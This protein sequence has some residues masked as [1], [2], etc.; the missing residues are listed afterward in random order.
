MSAGAGWLVIDAGNSAIK[1]AHSD[2]EG[3]RFLGTGVEVRLSLEPL[4]QRLATVWRVPRAR[5]AFGCCV[6][7]DETVASI[8]R[9]TREAAGIGVTWLHAQPHFAGRGPGYGLALINTYRDARELHADRWH[10]MIAACAKFPGESLVIATS[11][12]T[13]TVDCVHGEPAK[14]AVFVGGVIAPGQQP[15]V[16]AVARSTGRL[17][18]ANG[19]VVTNPDNTDDAIVTGV[20]YAQIGLIERKTRDFAAELARE[21]LPPPRLLLAGGRVRPLLGP[22][23]R[24]L[25]ADRYAY[26]VSIEDNL[27]LRG[28]ALRAHAEVAESG[29][30]VLLPLTTTRKVKE[31]IA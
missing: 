24:T 23:A 27:V 22:L 3:N 6:A 1:W 28:V 13:V 11:G 16:D 29:H 8:E 10:A 31:R 25:L 19:A 30:Q 9:A 21:G 15:M 5:A 12:T 2:A 7:D 4:A 26:A 14:A 17:P 20:T 18:A